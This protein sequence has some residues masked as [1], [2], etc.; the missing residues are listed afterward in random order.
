MLL[1]ELLK[2]LFGG[3]AGGRD[4]PGQLEQGDEQIAYVVVIFDQQN[5]RSREA[6]LDMIGAPP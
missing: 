2:R 4:E 1:A 5:A 3:R 6:V